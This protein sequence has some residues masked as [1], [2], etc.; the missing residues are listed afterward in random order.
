M[1]RELAGLTS[2]L[3]LAACSRSFPV[4]ATFE[5]GHI[6]FNA[7]EKLNGCLYHFSVS[8]SNGEMMWS[9]WGD[10]KSTP[11]DDLFPII[12]G[13]VPEGLTERSRPKPL[14]EG[15][16]YRIE[17]SDGDRYYGAFSYSRTIVV[18]NRPEIAR[19]P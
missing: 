4:E 2:L 18:E 19:A 9:V 10:F 12:Y 14:K 1:V 11:C 16:S 5:D 6:V 3:L 8:A 13:V 15:I 7:K 17:G